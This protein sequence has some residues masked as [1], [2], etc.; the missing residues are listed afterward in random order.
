M[1]ETRKK[2]RGRCSD[3]LTVAV[4][5]TVDETV[6][7]TPTVDVGEPERK[8]SH[9]VLTFPVS[10]EQIEL[11]L[12]ARFVVA[13]A[14]L[15]FTAGGATVLGFVSSSSKYKAAAVEKVFLRQGG[16]CASNR[17]QIYRRDSSLGH[18]HCCDIFARVC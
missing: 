13:F 10:D 5:V 12:L 9:A 11:M 8:Q 17:G 1:G 2:F 3:R 15:N 7:V 6:V 16:H 18:G 4:A 14:R